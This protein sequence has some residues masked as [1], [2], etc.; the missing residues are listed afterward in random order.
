MRAALGN[1]DGHICWT[2]I[3]QPSSIQLK[4]FSHRGGC[5]RA[6]SCHSNLWGVGLNASNDDVIKRKT[7]PGVDGNNGERWPSG[8]IALHHD[9]WP[10]VTITG[11]TRPLGS[12]LKRGRDR[13][14]R[15]TKAHVP[16]AATTSCDLFTQANTMTHATTLKSTVEDIPARPG[17][18][19]HWSC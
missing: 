19:H 3:I 8:C 17:F 4:A 7:L 18:L 9:S 15:F 2:A 13:K 14:D 11:P 5:V 1:R 16:P 6:S 12:A 10:K